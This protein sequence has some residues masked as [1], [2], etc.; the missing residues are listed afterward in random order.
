RTC[1]TVT[2]VDELAAKIAQVRNQGWSLVDQEL[3]E[4][5]VSMAAPIT[6][7]SGHTIAAINISGQANRTSAKVMQETML[8][9]LLAAAQSISSQLTI[10]RS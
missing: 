3:E 7:R 9:R 10:Q 4:G 6:D 1:F 5:L 8:P 2:D